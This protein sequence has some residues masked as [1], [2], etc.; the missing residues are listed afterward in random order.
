MAGTS[1]NKPLLCKLGL[2]KWQNYG[3]KIEVFWRDR[4]RATLYGPTYERARG[5]VVYKKRRCKRCGIKLRRTLV[6]NSDGTLSCIGWETDTGET[7]GE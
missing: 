7:D 4:P 1:V 6:T 5:E 2:H 3:E